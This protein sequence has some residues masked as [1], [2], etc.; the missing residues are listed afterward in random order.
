[1][2][3]ATQI[4]Q[5]FMNICTN[6]AQAM[7][8]TGGMLHVGLS[9]VYLGDAFAE[10]LKDIEP[11][12]YLEIKISDTGAGIPPED[13]DHIFDPYF[14]T[15]ESGKGTGMGLSTVHGIL[16]AYNGGIKVESTPGEGST[17]TVYL[18]V[19]KRRSRIDKY[20]PEHLPAGVERVL[21]IDDEPPVAKMAAMILQR[22][23]YRTTVR[24]DSLKALE[25]FRTHADAYDLVVTDMSM[26]NMSGDR[27]AAEMI[28]I[29]PDIPIILCTGYSSRISE[30]TARTIGI[31]AFAMK[32]L[33]KED[34]AKTV[35]KV[36]DDSRRTIA[37]A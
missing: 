20:T 22:L 33:A 28:R 11:G 19:T 12:D 35:R 32:P 30:E 24:T 14:T 15:K 36:L 6:A 31:K 13:L 7:E 4:H 5:L 17:F 34:L 29:R 10:T 26:P 1:L 2:G 3:D 25:D 37:G 23:G 8:S 18:P 9:D 21:I 27:L 16:R